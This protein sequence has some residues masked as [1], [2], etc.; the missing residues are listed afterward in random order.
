MT[1]TMIIWVLAM[2]LVLIAFYLMIWFKDYNDSLK[3]TAKLDAACPS[4]PLEIQEVYDDWSKPP[5][6]RQG[7]VHCY[8]LSIKDTVGVAAAM[9]NFT[10]V[11]PD[12]PENPCEEWLW[13]YENAL[14]LT[15]LSGAMVGAINGIVCFIFEAVAP[16]EKCL[17]YT[18]ED[19]GIFER[20]TMIQFLNIGALFIFSDFTLGFDRKSFSI[21]I[22][23]GNHK[24]FDTAWYYEVGA[25][26]SMAMVSNSIAPHG[27]KFAEPFI[28]KIL[29]WFLDRCCKK[30]LK[31]KTNIEEE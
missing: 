30:H 10:K 21:P 3:M 29:R 16:F 8:C 26:I 23:V 18:D 1:R 15:V 25:K 9:K 6:Q 12:I 24:D 28:K 22:L 31:R 11:D 27:G 7:Y 14:I 20:I 19:R 4:E 2:I 5:K 13:I 17:C